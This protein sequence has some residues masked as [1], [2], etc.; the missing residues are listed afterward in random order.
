MSAQREADTSRVRLT[1][2][3]RTLRRSLP[4]R[5][6]VTERDRSFLLAL[7]RTRHLTTSLVALLLFQG[8][9]RIANRRARKLLDLGL[10]R[11]WVT[12]LS[13]DNV[14]GLTAAGRRV[15][16][17]S[18]EDIPD[19]IQCPRE[20]DA[21]WEHE[22]AINSVRVRLAID[23]DRSGTGLSWW[24]SNRELRATGRRS[25]IP[26]ALFAIEWPE[27][28]AQVCALEVEYRTRAPQSFLK[29][30]ARYAAASYRPAGICGEPS[31]V[32]L[33]V[34]Q[35]PTWLNRYCLA[36]SQLAMPITIGFAALFDIERKGPTAAIWQTPFDDEKVSLRTLANCGYRN[37]TPSPETLQ[38]SSTIE[39]PAAHNSELIVP[40]KQGRQ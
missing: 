24:C 32:V 25:T 30:V 36:T 1:R 22:L 15:L 10:I 35:D 29:K 5:T 39:V 18:E 40:H 14:Y 28:P 21:Q 7:A 4:A 3:P 8:S 37:H 20:L 12:A 27:S 31:A 16:E 33:V 9:R 13:Q 34:G 2:Q 6:R 17:E 26:D 11:C 23:L 38:Q 19:T